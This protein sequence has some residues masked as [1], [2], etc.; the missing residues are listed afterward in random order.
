MA[1]FRLIDF[2]LAALG[3]VEEV[4]LRALPHDLL[5]LRHD[6]P[7]HRAHDLAQRVGLEATEEEVVTH[8][9]EQH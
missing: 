6:D 9:R 3:D 5:P 4:R 7:F 2:V 1:V 8:H